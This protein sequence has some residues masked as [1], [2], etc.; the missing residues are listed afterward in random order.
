[1]A[2]DTHRF[3]FREVPRTGFFGRIFG[4]VPRETAFIEIRNLLATKRLGDIT[5]EDVESILA[6]AKV[7]PAN[8]HDD[9]VG[10]YEQAALNLSADLELS[11]DDS[12]QLSRLEC[13][14]RLTS[15][16]AKQARERAAAATFLQAM[17]EALVDNSFTDDEK[18]KLEATA[19]GLG[20]APDEVKRVYEAA[21]TAAVQGLFTSVTADQ[22]YTSSEEQLVEALATSLGVK[23]I[24]AGNTGVAVERFRLLGRIAEGHIPSVAVP[25][26]LQRGETCHFATPSAIH[27]EMRVVTKRVNYGGPTASIKIMKGVRWRI[28][29]VSVQRVTQ[30]VLAPIDTGDFYIT[31]KRIIFQGIRKNTSITLGKIINFVVYADGI[32]IQKASG[33]DMYVIGS[34]DWE[35]AGACLEAAWVKT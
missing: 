32:Q 22:R 26:M 12:Q 11:S 30:D 25:I 1:L 23:I 7:Q 19:K 2:N 4:K 5:P 8:A 17:R 24:F 14:F 9:L 20:M 3:E 34:A 31:S 16:A 10:V 18:A 21:A 15:T 27:K 13:A 35:L 6:K 28:G 29:S 33:K